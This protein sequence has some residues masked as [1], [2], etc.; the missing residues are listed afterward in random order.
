MNKKFINSETFEIV[1]NVFEVDEYIV[2]TISLLNKKGYHTKY[3]CA[4]HVKDPRIYELYENIH[5][6]DQKYNEI[7]YIINKNEDICNILMPYISTQI[8]IMFDKNYN[9]TIL[10][11]GFYKEDNIIKKK[12]EYYLGKTKINSKKI[13]K[14]IREANNVLLEW[15]RELPYSNEINDV[16]RET[17]R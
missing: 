9:F 7:G 6:L 15:A 11:K 10:P 2:E 17:S 12:I 4:G 8:Y 3:C 16:S 1:D 13:D 5:N 14:M